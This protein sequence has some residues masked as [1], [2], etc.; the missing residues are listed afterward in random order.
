MNF[1]KLMERMTEIGAYVYVAA[2]GSVGV[3]VVRRGFSVVVF[4]LCRQFSRILTGLSHKTKKVTWRVDL[5]F[6]H[7]SRS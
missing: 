3:V 5:V 4:F 2:G 7:S 6:L 1:G